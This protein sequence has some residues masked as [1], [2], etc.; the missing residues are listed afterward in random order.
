MNNPYYREVTVSS[1][2]GTGTARGLAR[3]YGFL[4]NGGKI[5][6]KTLLSEESVR[7]LATPVVSGLDSVMLTGEQSTIG[8]G[9]LYRKNP[10]VFA[11]D[12]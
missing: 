12:T 7:R 6:S 2:S 10:K 8:L 11:A 3:L 4:A 1:L 5:D 9:T